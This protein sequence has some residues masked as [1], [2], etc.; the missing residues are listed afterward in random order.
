MATIQQLKQKDGKARYRAQVRLRGFPSQSAYFE[1]KTD[2]KAWASD[3]EAA[4]RDG[5]HFPT[6]EAKR[7][8][9]A[10][11]VD[12]RLDWIQSK[13]PYAFKQQSIL[14][15]WWKASIG[16]Y[17]L[18]RLTPALIA[19]CRDKLL[20]E[21]IG[22]KEYPRQRVPST[23]NRFL[24]ALSS[25][26][27]DAVQEWQWLQENPV[28]RVSKEAESAGRIRYLSDDERKALL[29]ACRKSPLTE[30]YLIVLLTVTTGMR[31]GEVIG[32]RWSDVDFN[33]KTIV[34]HKTKTGE[35]RSVPIVP[36]ALKLLRKHEKVRR[37]DTDLL[38]P[39]PKDLPIHFD[40]YWRDALA[41]AGIE[42]FRFHD[43]RHTAAS[44]LAM[45]GATIPE[46]AAVLGHKTLQMV[47]RYAHL[48]DQHVGAVIE[49]MNKKY[50]DV[51]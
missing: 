48:S 40:A 47:K 10:D 32:L 49:R 12:R 16:K 8:T 31:R 1:R 5:R 36:T 23:A 11:L 51:S 37:A 28:R 9:V 15:E 6:H 22:T 50:F 21:N 19:E 43:L 34:L 14:L 17:A 4:I 18:S 29:V 33:R 2:A 35:R 7:H 24:A 3:T 13:R 41:D 38:F 44:Y 45:S 39:G 27:K 30:L 26:C 42:D 20:K 25:A 46:I